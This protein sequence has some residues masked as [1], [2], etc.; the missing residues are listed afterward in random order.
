MSSVT[1][2]SQGKR[3]ATAIGN[4]HL[5]IFKISSGIDESMLEDI[6]QRELRKSG[7]ALRRRISIV[8]E[9]PIC[10]TKETRDGTWR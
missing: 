6:E 4:E 2:N 3:A 5:R 7:K 1:K 9:T 8:I 10:K